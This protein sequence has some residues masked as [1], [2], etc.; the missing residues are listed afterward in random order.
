MNLAKGSRLNRNN[1][2]YIAEYMKK[3]IFPLVL[4]EGPKL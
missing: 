2:D 1:N 3:D 4:N